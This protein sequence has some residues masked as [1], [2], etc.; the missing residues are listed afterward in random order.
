VG[1]TT[2]NVANAN[3]TISSMDESESSIL[4]SGT[5]IANTGA[6]KTAIIAEGMTNWSRSRLNFLFKWC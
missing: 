4:Y 1:N 6:Y 2:V 3:F 5:S